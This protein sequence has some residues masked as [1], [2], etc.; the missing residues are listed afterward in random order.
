MVSAP[1]TRWYFDCTGIQA[2][3]RVNNII[4]EE[5]DAIHNNGRTPAGIDML[6]SGTVI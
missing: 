1:P 4:G 5:W 6:S 2:G 3:D